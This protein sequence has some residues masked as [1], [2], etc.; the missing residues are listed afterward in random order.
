[1]SPRTFCFAIAAC[2]MG[3]ACAQMPGGP[4]PSPPPGARILKCDTPTCAVKVAIKCEAYIFCWIDVDN[5]WIQ[6]RPGNSPEI[7]WEITT[8]GYRFSDNGIAFPAGSPFTC[9][10]AEAGRRFMCNDRHS[11]KGI[12]K[13][14][15]TVL[16]FPFVF[17]KDPWVDNQ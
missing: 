4:P 7:T 1:M 17:P 11:E 9:H 12:Y 14:A 2:L 13:Y 15:I 3:G 10:R 16:G 5:D 8:S 6:V